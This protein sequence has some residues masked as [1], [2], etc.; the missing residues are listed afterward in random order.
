MVTVNFSGHTMFFFLCILVA[1]APAI[2]DVVFHDCNCSPF[3]FFS[4]V[5]VCV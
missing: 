1:V 5:G 4:I 2:A 3:L